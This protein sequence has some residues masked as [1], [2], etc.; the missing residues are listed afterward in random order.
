MSLFHLYDVYWK[1][2][3]FIRAQVAGRVLNSGFLS[4]KRLGVHC[5]VTPSTF[6]GTHLYVC[7]GVDGRR[8]RKQ[9]EFRSIGFTIDG[10]TDEEL[11]ARYRF[12]KELC[13]FA[14]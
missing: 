9:R 2:K 13:V 5:R 10:Y 3:A 6:A 14:Y 1:Q 12:G 7:V 8:K 11:R 4:M